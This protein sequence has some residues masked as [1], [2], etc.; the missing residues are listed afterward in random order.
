MGLLG[1][2]MRLNLGAQQSWCTVPANT[3][4]GRNN[5]S[6]HTYRGIQDGNTTV[7]AQRA[8][9]LGSYPEGTYYPPEEVGQMAFRPV[10]SGILSGGLFSDL[11]MTIDLTGSGTLNADLGLV[12]SM[13]CAMSGNGEL[14]ADI[15]GVINASANLTGS[16]GLSGDIR[17]VASMMIDMLGEGDLEA[18]IAAYGNMSIDM[19]VTGTGLTTSNVG[20]AVWAA[21]QTEINNAGT[22]GAAL[23]AAGSAGDPWSTTLPASYTGTQA[24]AILSEIERLVER[25][26]RIQGLEVGV[27]STTDRNTGKWIAGDIDLDLTGDFINETTITANT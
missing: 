18:T 4:G 12:V 17:G 13:L 27:P 10:G 5:F 9:P 15:V 16:G 7:L 26:H 24:G 19:V 11:L 3:Q 6:V 20:A 23:L 25:L 1:N 2:N 8:V 14:S 21:L 22:A